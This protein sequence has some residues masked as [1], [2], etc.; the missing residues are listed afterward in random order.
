MENIKIQKALEAASETEAFILGD[1]CKLDT[2]EI[3][4]KYFSNQSLEVCKEDIDQLNSGK[5][6]P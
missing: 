6:S 1:G 3:F 5:G 2:P 4:Q